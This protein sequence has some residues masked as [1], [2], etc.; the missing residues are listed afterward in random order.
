MN[1]QERVGITFIVVTHDQEE[2]MT[3]STRMAVMEEGRIK[4]LGVPHDVYEYP[5][6]RFVA[7][8]IG[9]VNILRELSLKT[10][11]IIL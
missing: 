8:F 2:A 3:M 6:S 4:Q 1:I 9:S 10:K 11:L 5:N 7:E